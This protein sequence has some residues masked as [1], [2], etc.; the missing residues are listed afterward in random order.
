MLQWVSTWINCVADDV[1]ALSVMI[2]VLRKLTTND[3]GTGE[4]QICL[5]RIC[6]DLSLHQVLLGL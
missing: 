3:K 2:Q 6:S 1:N 5:H 4:T